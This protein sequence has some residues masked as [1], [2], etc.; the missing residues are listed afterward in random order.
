MKKLP[1]FFALDLAT[2][3]QALDL[4]QKTKD[5]VQAYKIGPRLFL[6]HG[7]KLIKKIK[8]YGS[9]VFLDF[10]FY[11]IPSSTLEAIRS[12]FKIGANFVTVHASVGKETLDLLSQ[13]EKEVSQNNVFQILFVTVLSSVV[14]SKEN[15]N[16]IFQLLNQFIRLVSEDWYVPLG[17]QRL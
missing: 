14:D 3:E 17:K 8:A 1:L 4:V 16:K 13:F 11:D 9:Q 2:E 5:Y 15:Q 12:A 7:P 6:A 10:K